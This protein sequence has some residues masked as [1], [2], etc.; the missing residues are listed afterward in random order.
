LCLIDGGLYT[1]LAGLA[2]AALTFLV[3]RH[4]AGKK[5]CATPCKAH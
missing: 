1:D 5:T 4:L 3:Q 2:V